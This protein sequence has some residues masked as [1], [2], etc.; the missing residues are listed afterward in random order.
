MTSR[1]PS[2]KLF[3]KKWLLRKVNCCTSCAMKFW[4]LNL[5]VVM[6]NKWLYEHYL[7]SQCSLWV[8]KII[9]WTNEGEYPISK[10]KWLIDFQIRIEH[11]WRLK[12]FLMANVC[13]NRWKVLIPTSCSAVWKTVFL[14]K[15]I[16]HGVRGLTNLS[17]GQCNLLGEKGGALLISKNF[18]SDFNP[19]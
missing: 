6:N 5:K 1:D 16:R 19:R 4:V 11:S 17:V 2:Y 12:Q 3:Q 18:K 13:V 14:G 8:S 10:S 9:C 7:N 15:W